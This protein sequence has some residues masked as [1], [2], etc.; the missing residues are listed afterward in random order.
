MAT[1]SVGV[2]VPATVVREAAPDAVAMQSANRL[3]VGEQD[4]HRGRKVAV[5]G[6]FAH[7][8]RGD[9]VGVV[10]G[11]GVARA[12]VLLAVVGGAAVAGAGA[13]LGSARNSE[14]SGD[15]C[16]VVGS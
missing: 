4:A 10:V 8:P 7:V 6:H 15:A 9:A 1:D 16:W 3:A 13:G 5:H 11:I 2:A 14:C 12:A